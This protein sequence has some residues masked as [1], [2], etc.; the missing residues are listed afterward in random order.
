MVVIGH[1]RIGTEIDSKDL[2]QDCPTADRPL[3]EIFVIL[4]GIVILPTKKARRTQ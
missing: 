1:H 3:T 2:R 4:A